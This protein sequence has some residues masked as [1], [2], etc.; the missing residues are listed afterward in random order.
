M[1]NQTV[2]DLGTDGAGGGTLKL[3]VEMDMGNVEVIR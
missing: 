2:T 1:E 3:D